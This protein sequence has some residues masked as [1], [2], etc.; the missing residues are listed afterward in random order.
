MQR[1]V[2]RTKVACP[3]SLVVAE[4][5]EDLFRHLVKG[6][7][8]VHIERFDGL[9]ESDEAHLR[10]LHPKGPLWVSVMSQFKYKDEQFEFLDVGRKI[11]WPLMSWEH[12]HRVEKIGEDHAVVCDDITFTSFPGT[13]FICR[14]IFTSD[15]KKRGPKYKSYF[16]GSREEK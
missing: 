14:Q 4:F 3:F 11:P 6:F 2:V 1:I 13:E 8:P 16:E 7:P 9:N 15:M 10:L 12:T 5:N